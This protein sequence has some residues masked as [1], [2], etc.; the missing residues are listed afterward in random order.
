M[1]CSP[2]R[3][4][5]PRLSVAVLWAWRGQAAH[6]HLPRLV[7]H[8][9]RSSG[10]NRRPQS[11]LCATPRR[12]KQKYNMHPP[13]PRRGPWRWSSCRHPRAAACGAVD[14]ASE[15]LTFAHPARRPQRAPSEN[16]RG[17]QSGRAPRTPPLSSVLAG[18][19]E[20]GGGAMVTLA[21]P[22]ALSSVHWSHVVGWGLPLLVMCPVGSARWARPSSQTC[23]LILFLCAFRVFTAGGRVVPALFIAATRRLDSHQPPGRRP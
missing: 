17:V 18:H 10:R 22:A 20:R 14:H 23:L 5:G 13:P 9:S 16:P 4:S 6:V 12:N 7:N 8:G 19:L 2:A 1:A 21:S 11:G 15:A 3:P